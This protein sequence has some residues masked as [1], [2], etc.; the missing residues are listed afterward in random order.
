MQSLNIE[1]HNASFK[2]SAIGKLLINADQVNFETGE[3]G[4]LSARSYQFQNKDLVLDEL[5][6]SLK[7]IIFLPD[8]L[9]SNQALILQQPVQAKAYTLVTE[10]GIN[11]ILNQP[12][13]LEKLSNITKTK[14]KKFG[15]NLS[16][17]LISFYEPKARILENNRIEILMTGALSNFVSFPVQYTTTLAVQNSKLVLTQPTLNTSGITL[18]VEVTQVLNDKLS[19]LLDIDEKLKEDVDVNIV[20]LQVLPGDKIIV[21]ADATIR[22]LKFSKKEN[23]DN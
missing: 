16:S 11:S 6:I 19:S 1:L 15:I 18:P 2:K 7:N 22:K 21:S 14:I 9:L 8:E 4:S 23:N 10:K 3:I 12:K 20:G 17:G 13:V 5:G